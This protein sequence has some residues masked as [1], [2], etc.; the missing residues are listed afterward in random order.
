MFYIEI[1]V[2]LLITVWF[3]T[4]SDSLAETQARMTANDLRTLKSD[5]MSKKLVVD[6]RWN[7]ED[8]SNTIFATTQGRLDSIGKRGCHPDRCRR[9]GRN[10]DG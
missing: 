3:S 1:A 6:E 7:K 10:R 8:S 4:L 5:V 9:I 2:I